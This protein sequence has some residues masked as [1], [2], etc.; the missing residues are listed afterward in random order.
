ML[1]ADE[2]EDPQASYFRPWGSDE[3]RGWWGPN[4]PYHHAVFVLA[5]HPRDLIAMEGGTTFHFVV[6]GIDAALEQAF[7]AANAT[8]V[9]LGG[10]ASTVQQYL[11]GGLIDELHAAVVP[12]L[13]RRG[14]RLFHNLDGGPEG[15]ECVDFVSSPSAAHFRFARTTARA[16]PR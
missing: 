11:A 8:D 6:D 2:S 4:P 15:Y 14:E 5:H 16:N 13:L 1:A 7:A 10:G 3:W 12:V 9:R